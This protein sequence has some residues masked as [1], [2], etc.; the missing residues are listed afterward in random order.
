MKY[1]NRILDRIY[2]KLIGYRSHKHRNKILRHFLG[3]LGSNCCICTDRFAAEPQWIYIED[4]VVVA[5][6]VEFINHDASCWN[7]YRSLGL[8]CNKQHEKVGAIILRKNCFIG[9]RAILL[10]G[11]EIGDNS[12]VGAGSIVTQ[13]IPPNEVCVC[14]WVPAHYLMSFDE[15][16]KKMEKYYFSLKWG[17]CR[18]EELKSMQKQYF[19]YQYECIRNFGDKNE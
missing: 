5:S 19:D 8:L 6:E 9:A 15:Y 1:F 11:I 13:S 2:L 3:H 17:T 18:M 12:V 10:P 7:A 14:V 4:N 16:C